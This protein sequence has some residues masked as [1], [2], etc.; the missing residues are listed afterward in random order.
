M[1]CPTFSTADAPNGPTCAINSQ[2]LSP[3]RFIDANNKNHTR[4]NYQATSPEA[5]QFPNQGLATVRN[6][7]VAVTALQMFERVLNLESPPM[8]WSSAW[9]DEHPHSSGVNSEAAAFAQRRSRAL[10]DAFSTWIMADDT[11]RREVID[12]YNRT[13]NSYV[14]ANWDGS[15]RSFPGL[16]TEFTPYSYQR[17]A[18]ERINNE[19]AVLLNHCVGAGKTGTFLMG[20]AELKRLGLIHQPWIVVPNHIAEQV[21]LE[22][23]RWYPQARVLSAAGIST[24]EERRTFVAQTTSQDWDFVIV[25]QSVFSKIPMTPETQLNYL[26]KRRDENLRDVAIIRVEQ[27]YPFPEKAVAAALA[28]YKNADIIWCQEEPRNQGAWRQIYESLAPALPGGKR[29]HYAGRAA[30]ASTAA[31]YLKMHNAEQAALVRDALGITDK[32]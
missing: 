10:R 18:V 6:D 12:A 9:T 15:Y 4:F 1:R 32:Q 13:F 21:T 26:Q 16:G 7:G 22:A 5:R 11:R 24:P 3:L 14:A 20:A 2:T 28:P 25:P 30:S 19:P 27:L 31:G 8:N 29:P 17:N 23:N